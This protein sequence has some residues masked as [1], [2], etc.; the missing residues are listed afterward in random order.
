MVE[1]PRNDV[2]V[3]DTAGSGIP[4]AARGA[5]VPNPLSLGLDELR[6]R[7]DQD[8]AYADAMAAQ[9]APSLFLIIPASF[10]YLVIMFVREAALIVLAATSAISP[11]VWRDPAMMAQA[12]RQVAVR[13]GSSLTAPR[14][15]DRRSPSRARDSA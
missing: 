12:A 7:A 3:S 6:Q 5:T 14:R 4:S 1:S 2:Q 15:I 13:P 11:A 8:R 10:F 9:A